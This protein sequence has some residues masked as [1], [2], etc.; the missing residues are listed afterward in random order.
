IRGADPRQARPGHA[1]D[2][3]RLAIEGDALAD[4]VSRRGKLALPQT[5]AKDGH[6]AGTGLV[7]FRA[8]IATGNRSKT[9][10]GEELGGN[11]V[12]VE[13]LR[14]ARTGEVVVLGAE[15]AKRLKGMVLLLPVQEVWI[16]NRALAEGRRPRVHRIELVRIGERQRIHEHAVD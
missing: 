13:A 3:V 5:V 14:L 4:D 15:G 8:E 10:G 6:R 2:R 11:H 1:H 16:A 7:L 12:R 9:E